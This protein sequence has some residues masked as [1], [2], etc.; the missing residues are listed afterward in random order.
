MDLNTA[1]PE[2][3]IVGLRPANSGRRIPGKIYAVLSLRP[4][5]VRNAYLFS[6]APPPA[7]SAQRTIN[8]YG[9]HAHSVL[10]N[11]FLAA[12]QNRL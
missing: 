4:R 5:L 3:R 9:P 10:R 6:F 11:I 12:P 7:G 1:F 8:L 2:Q